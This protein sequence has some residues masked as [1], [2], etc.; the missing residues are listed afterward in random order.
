[1]T[2]LKNSVTNTVKVRQKWLREAR[3][4]REAISCLHPALQELQHNDSSIDTIEHRLY[5][6]FLLPCGSEREDQRTE[7]LAKIMSAGV[8]SGITWDD[9][10]SVGLVKNF[11]LYGKGKYDHKGE[12][13]DVLITIDNLDQPPTCKLITTKEMQEIS[14]YK[15]ECLDGDEGGEEE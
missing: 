10:V 12:G 14:I 11:S 7:E 2:T 8:K 3:E 4:A 9:W 13:R 1:M 15:L 6:R 5:I